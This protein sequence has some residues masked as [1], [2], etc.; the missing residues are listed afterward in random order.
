MPRIDLESI[1][2]IVRGADPEGL[3]AGGAPQDEYEPEEDELYA[4]LEHLPATEMTEEL[5]HQ[6]LAAIWES[7]FDSESNPEREAGL[8][9]IVERIV[10]FFGPDSVY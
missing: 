6:F 4:E 3:L 8:Q 7:A 5:V 2:D 10:H 1:Q 9:T